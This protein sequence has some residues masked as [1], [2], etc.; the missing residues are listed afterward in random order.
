MIQKYR[1]SIRSIWEKLVW[2]LGKTGW[3]LGED[4]L[5]LWEKLW[6]NWHY[7]LEKL[8]KNRS[9]LGL[10]WDKAQVS[11]VWIFEDLGLSVA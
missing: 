1:L 2:S 8:G 5:G 11:C 9:A 7:F 10:T 6:K 4:W 3:V